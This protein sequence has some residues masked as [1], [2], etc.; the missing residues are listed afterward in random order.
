MKQRSVFAEEWRE[1]LRAHYTHVVRIQDVLTERTL[2]SVMQ[3]AG[4]SD[5]D[6]AN[7]RLQATMH[8]DDVDPDFQP[9]P[10][11]VEMIQASM[12]KNEPETASAV[13]VEVEVVGEEDEEA[14]EAA[15]AEEEAPPVSEEYYAPPDDDPHQLSLF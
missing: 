15:E 7:L 1:C 3:E 9:D 13:E 6:L 2:I 8:M 11:T 4:F 12:P 14:E 10:A 5:E